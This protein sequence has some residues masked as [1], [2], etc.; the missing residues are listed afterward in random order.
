[1]NFKDNELTNDQPKGYS[2][3]IVEDDTEEKQCD[4]HTDM[5]DEERGVCCYSDPKWNKW[6]LFTSVLSIVI[7]LAMIFILV[8]IE[9]RHN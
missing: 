2:T 1:M 7:I 3:I 5:K 6:I 4:E 8:A 9:K